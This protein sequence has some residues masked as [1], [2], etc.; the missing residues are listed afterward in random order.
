MPACHTADVSD[1]LIAIELTEEE[2]YV[3]N[4]GLI[5]WGGPSAATESLAKAMGFAGT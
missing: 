2:R 4:Y 3:L 1:D 5:D